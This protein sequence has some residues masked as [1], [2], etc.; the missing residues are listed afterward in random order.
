MELKVKREVKGS[1]F[2]A[3]K[4][5]INDTYFCYTLEDKD[6]GLTSAMTTAQIKQIKVPAET[7]IPIGRYE[8]VINFSNRFQKQMPLLIGVKGFEGIRIHSGNKSEHTEGCLLVGFEDG[9]DGFMGES[10]MAVKQL[11]SKLFETIK[12]EKIWIT[13]E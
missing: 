6:R 7:A 13:Y 5:L 1:N 12:V 4:L 11:Y 10:K 8:V 9:L 3:G 2:T